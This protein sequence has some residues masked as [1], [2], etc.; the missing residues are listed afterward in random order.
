MLPAMVEDWLFDE[1]DRRLMETALAEARAAAERGEIP[2][3]AVVVREGQILARAGNRRSGKHD[4]T[5]HAE[6]VVLREAGRALGD[7][8]LAGCTLYVTLEPCPM[9]TAA[10]RQA[11]LDLVIW[12]AADPVTGACGTVLD[13]AEDP[14]LGP[15]LA[16]RGGLLAEPA[17]ELLRAFFAK[18]RRNA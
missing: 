7:W 13:L 11:R 5:G 6:L 9:C 12:G 3:G 1:E 16:Q 15:P 18:R 2:V 8:R 4:P 17:G 10:C 14:R